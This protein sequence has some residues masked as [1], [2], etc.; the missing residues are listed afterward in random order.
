MML[1]VLLG[2]A[3]G[4]AGATKVEWVAHRG[5]SADAP[6]NT[7]AAF[8]LAWERGVPAIELDVH[9]S[10][11]GA[12]IVSHDADTERTTGTKLVIKDS[13][14]DELRALDAGCWKDPRWAGE[15]LPTLGESLATIPKDAR[16]FIEIKVGPEIVPALVETIRE[17]GKTPAQ[18]AIISFHADTIAEA[19]RRLPEIPAYYLASFR[20]D[21]QTGAWEPTAADLIAKAREIQA[22]GLDLA[23]K[24]PI[25]R[26]FVQQVKDAGLKFYVWTVDDPA[27]AHRLIAAGVDGITTNK[28][29]WMQRQLSEEDQPCQVDGI[30]R[31]E[32]PA[33][34]DLVSPR[35]SLGDRAEAT[36]GIPVR[37]SGAESDL[38]VEV[39]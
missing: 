14:L 39:R 20:Q 8:R 11:D 35:L 22:D 10:K 25:D 9:Q 24:G 13:T 31:L 26:E 3:L 21:K 2:L 28:A 30:D 15:K 5:E 16:C 6:E 12:L 27:E 33:I 23:F 18:L 4:P 32:E 17:S 1:V 36:P 38:R 19:K 29:A 7:M 37:L 34:A